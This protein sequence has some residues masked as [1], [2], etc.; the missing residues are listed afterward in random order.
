MLRVRNFEKF[1]HYRNRRPPWIKLHRS[2]L[3]DYHFRRLHDASKAH[4]MLLWVVAS[5]CDNALH[6]DVEWLSALIG[7]ITPIDIDALVSAGF[8]ERYDAD[9]RKPRASKMLAPRKQNADSEGE[10]E[11]EGETEKRTTAADPQTRGSRPK[12]PAKDRETWLTPIGAA[13]ES[14]NGAGSFPYGQ[15]ARELAPLRKAG[16]SPDEIGRRLEWYLKVRG[17]DTLDPDPDVIARTRFTPNLRDFRLRHAKFDR[18][19]AA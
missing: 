6:D 2:V 16:L 17:L 8:L 12:G 3:E 5:G 9:K 13:W 7:A 19:R 1:Q 14:V 18:D 10:G 4:A 15:A 11:G